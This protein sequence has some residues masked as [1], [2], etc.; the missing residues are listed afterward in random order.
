MPASLKTSRRQISG[1]QRGSESLWQGLS[2]DKLPAANKIAVD[3]FSHCYN[4][5]D[6][7]GVKGE[8]F[9]CDLRKG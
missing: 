4:T 8:A 6:A 2:S 1:E 9:K 5:C 3:M 7:D